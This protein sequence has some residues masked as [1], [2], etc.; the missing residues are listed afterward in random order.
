M[1]VRGRTGLAQDLVIEAELVVGWS[2]LAVMRAHLIR[3]HRRRRTNSGHD[4]AARV[5]RNVGEDSLRGG[6]RINQIALVAELV[7]LKRGRVGADG[8]QPQVGLHGVERAR[9]ARRALQLLELL[10]LL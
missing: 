3:R 6:I 8:R 4:Q 1:T 10:Q 2:H 5:S 7:V 9:R